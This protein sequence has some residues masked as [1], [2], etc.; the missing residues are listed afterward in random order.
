MRNERKK[1]GND[2][3][4]TME[5]ETIRKTEIHVNNKEEEGR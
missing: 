4:W 1:G 3:K 2:E 5:K